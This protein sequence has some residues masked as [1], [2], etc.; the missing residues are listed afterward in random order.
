VELVKPEFTENELAFITKKIGQ[1]IQYQQVVDEV[2]RGITVVCVHDMNNSV[3]YSVPLHK[4]SEGYLPTG[5]M[6]ANGVTVMDTGRKLGQIAVT[7]IT[8]N[9]WTCT[10][11]KDFVLHKVEGRCSKCGCS[12]DNSKDRLPYLNDLI[13]WELIVE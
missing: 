7:A 8:D 9:F 13:K 5:A 6:M 2:Y 10:C 4:G 12:L 11:K 3:L 1:G